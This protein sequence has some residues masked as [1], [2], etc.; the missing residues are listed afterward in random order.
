M[1]TDISIR[2]ESR[3]LKEE[4]HGKSGGLLAKPTTEALLEQ[5][6]NELKK[7][8]FNILLSIAKSR[9]PLT[10]TF[11]SEDGEHQIEA[12]FQEYSEVEL[13]LVV[14]IDS[15]WKARFEKDGLT[16]S[17]KIKKHE[18]LSI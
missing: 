3:D 5:H 10:Y 15:Q 8:D 12:F 6:L 4:Y 7:L 14:A 18:K 11:V 17:V 2:M 13:E 16:K 9:E 1:D